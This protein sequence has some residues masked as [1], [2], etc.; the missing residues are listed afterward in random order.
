MISNLAQVVKAK[1]MARRIGKIST[2][3]HAKLEKLTHVDLLLTG[4]RE[5]CRGT[6]ECQR[7]K[8]SFLQQK[9]AHTNTDKFNV[10]SF[11]LK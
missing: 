10:R 7:Q 8:L 11:V 9:D 1:K 6:A 2:T 5:I 3:E 4:V